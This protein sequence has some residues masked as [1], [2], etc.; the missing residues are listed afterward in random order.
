MWLLIQT[1]VYQIIQEG[2]AKV[3]KSLQINVITCRTIP[4]VALNHLGHFSIVCGKK[5][6]S[7][8]LRSNPM[9]PCGNNYF[10]RTECGMPPTAFPS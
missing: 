7:V 10:G 1:K 5:N 8:Q 6:I 2:G 3:V 9:L 4:A